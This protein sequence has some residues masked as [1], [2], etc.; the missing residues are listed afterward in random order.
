MEAIKVSKKDIASD[1]ELLCSV[2][3]TSLRTKVENDMADQLTEIVTD[4]ILMIAKPDQPIDL[5]MVEIM[6][7]RVFHPIAHADF[8]TFLLD[9]PSICK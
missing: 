8:H 1:R 9:G 5:H 7:V 6:H 2:S 4:A 3:S